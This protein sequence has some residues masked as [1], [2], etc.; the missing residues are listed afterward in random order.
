MARLESFLVALCVQSVVWAMLV[1]H[2][3]YSMP[4]AL[5]VLRC[6][7]ML[8]LVLASLYFALVM[9]GKPVAPP[10]RY[11]EDWLL[12]ASGWVFLGVCIW[13]GLWLLVAASVCFRVAAGF[14]RFVAGREVVNG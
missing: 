13:S 4:G 9:L 10:R 5:N 2:L 1:L 14:S 11:P 7:A 3:V 12:R 8:L 6:Y